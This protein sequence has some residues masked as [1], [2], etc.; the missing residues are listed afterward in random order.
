MFA[1]TLLPWEQTLCPPNRAS[2]MLARNNTAKEGGSENSFSSFYQ[3][4]VLRE[5]S[6]SGLCEAVK[7]PFLTL[8]VEVSRRGSANRI[9]TRSESQPEN[10][11]PSVSLHR[12]KRRQK[13]LCGFQLDSAQHINLGIESQDGS[14]IGRH[15]VPVS[16]Y[17]NNSVCNNCHRPA[18]RALQIHLRFYKHENLIIVLHFLFHVEF[19]WL[20]L[21]FLQ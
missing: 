21:L 19:H 1:R 8:T 6:P 16:I 14:T 11:C 5:E 9:F 10:T 18:H 4:E 7:C 20:E 12:S 2:F 17:W 13:H 15:R 3:K